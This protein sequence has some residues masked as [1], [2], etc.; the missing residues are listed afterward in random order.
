MDIVAKNIGGFNFIQSL[1]L[2]MTRDEERIPTVLEELEEFW[3][4]NPDLRLAQII[5][6]A[7]QERG[8]GDDVFYMEDEDLLR[9]L[10][11]KK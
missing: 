4:E 6:N 1:F 7:S 10:R 5:S 2:C 11:N 3:E 9:Y 8:Y